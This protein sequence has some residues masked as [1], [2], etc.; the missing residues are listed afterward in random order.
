MNKFKIIFAFLL[1]CGQVGFGQR[2]K[3]GPGTGIVNQYYTLAAALPASPATTIDINTIGNTV[4]PAPGDL[5]MIIQMQGATVEMNDTTNSNFGAINTYNN[6][7]KHEFAEVLKVQTVGATTTLTITCPLKNN[8]DFRYNLPKSQ[9]TTTIPQ[10][11]IYAGTQIIRVPRFTTLTVASGTTIFPAMA[12]N[13]VKG[14]VVVAEVM[15]DATVNGT[16]SATGRG[17]RGGLKKD[18]TKNQQFALGEI[19]YATSLKQ[20]GAPKGEGIGGSDRYP[21]APNGEIS[22]A[23]Q[24]IG[25]FGPAA[26]AN[27]GGGGHTHNSGGG[28]GANGLVNGKTIND[29]TGIGVPDPIYAAA[30]ALDP[31]TANKPPSPGGGRGGYSMAYNLSNYPGT[32][33]SGNPIPIYDGLYSPYTYGPGWSPGQPTNIPPNNPWGGDARKNI[34]GLGGRPLNY[35]LPNVVFLGGGGGAGDANDHCGVDG[36][37]GGGLVYLEVYGNIIGSGII[38]SNGADVAIM[39]PVIFGPGP[40]DVNGCKGNDATSG[41]GGGGAIILNVFKSI[42]N[43]LNI[44]ATGGAGGFEDIGRRELYNEPSPTKNSN[45]YYYEADGPGGGGGGGFIAFS[46]DKSGSLPTIDKI[47]GDTSG[48][49]TS[50]GKIGQEFPP[51]GATDGNYGQTGTVTNLF[52]LSATGGQTCD[53]SEFTL[54][55]SIA[56]ATGLQ[57]PTYTWYYK[58]YS[59]SDSIWYTGANYKLTRP[60]LKKLGPGTHTFWVNVC[61]GGTSN[62]DKGTYRDSAMVTIN[63]CGL[64]VNLTPDTTLCFGESTIIKA[65]AVGG[66]PNYTFKWYG[67]AGANLTQ[68]TNAALGTSSI[69]VSTPGKYTVSLID[70]SMPTKQKDSSLTGTTVTVI[71]PKFINPSADTSVC[72]NSSNITLKAKP[73]PLAPATGTFTGTDVTGNIFTPVHTGTN[74]S[75]PDTNLVRYIYTEGGRTCKDSLKIIVKPVPVFTTTTVDPRCGVQGSITLHGLPSGTTYDTLSYVFNSASTATVLKLQKAVPLDSIYIAPLQKGPY[76]KLFVT[77][78]GCKSAEANDTL[79]G[80]DIPKVTIN[81]TNIDRCFNDPHDTLFTT[82]LTNVDLATSSVSY[83]WKVD[84]VIQTLATGSTYSAPKSLLHMGTK[85]QV[86]IVVNPSLCPDSNSVLI[87]THKPLGKVAL[88]LPSKICEDS[89]FIISATPSGT[90]NIDYKLPMVFQWLVNGVTIPGQ[91]TT[92]FSKTGLKNNDEVMVIFDLGICGVKDT[93][94]V[95]VPAI[96]LPDPIISGRPKICA[97]DSDTLTVMT[98]DPPHPFAYQWLHNGQPISGANFAKYVAKDSGSYQV[99]VSNQGSTSDPKACKADTSF[100]VQVIK[101]GVDAGPDQSYLMDLSTD[102]HVDATKAIT[103]AGSIKPGA[104]GIYPFWTF[105]TDSDTLGLQRELDSLNQPTYKLGPTFTLPFGTYNF[106]L[107]DTAGICADSDFVQIILRENIWVP[108]AISPNQDPTHANETWQIRGLRGYKEYTV[109]VYNRYGNVVHHQK[110]PYDP[111]DGMRNGVPMPV[112]TYYWVI[113]VKGLDNYSGT[114]TIIR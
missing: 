46:S 69:T 16:I 113:E 17:F 53:T 56:P 2:G 93:A 33:A 49:T 90:V 105:L 44:S 48:I 112:G 36:G 11:G 109:N 95:H 6:A 3:D 67:P 73:V 66:H 51:E 26:I 18:E 64:K 61:S 71:Q 52:E 59:A 60:M 10:S 85:V 84:G 74:P 32:D 54:T 101:I 68:T 30:W 80:P 9:S 79:K 14:G 28:G 94:A 34:G 1:C 21:T 13:G 27:G 29:W 12:W 83:T 62:I 76:N 97:G 100:H 41:G 39:P 55:A 35:L 50:N 63:Q 42:S 31:T 38:E 77:L 58:N 91:T 7:G 72:E 37:N 78:K 99:I 89:V 98:T 87:K 47:K 23:Y 92:K 8:Y 19:N 104:T 45:Y 65:K 22:F 24:A 108:T 82:K 20:L 102:P 103:L 43:S 4:I 107:K 88:P 111:W 86:A 81:E 106:M 57:S 5:I 25:P 70:G 75:I 15:G 40:Y 96:P 110:Y 114:L